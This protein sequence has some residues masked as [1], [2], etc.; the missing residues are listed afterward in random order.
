MLPVSSPFF[1]SSSL[2]T[3]RD[4]VRH[5]VPA[6]VER[7][8]EDAAE[9]LAAEDHAHRPLQV[10][11]P[12]HAREGRA[13]LVFCRGMNEGT[14][15]SSGG[16]GR[17]HH[18]MAKRRHNN[19]TMNDDAHPH[20]I[21]DTEAFRKTTHPPPPATSACDRPRKRSCSGP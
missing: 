1:Q 4:E 19:D 12:L 7:G 10:L 5:V 9:A 13:R 17:N 16:Q 6:C 15:A 20:S 8:V 3:H 2:I 14:G 11:V 18:R 21:A